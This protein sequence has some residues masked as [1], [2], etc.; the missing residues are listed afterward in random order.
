MSI[1]SNTNN[2]IFEKAG[3]IHLDPKALRAEK[4]SDRRGSLSSHSSDGSLRSI[5]VSSSGTH[6]PKIA[7]IGIKVASF[8][9]RMATILSLGYWN[10][11]TKVSFDG[12]HTFKWLQS[13]SLSRYFF[14]V[15]KTTHLVNKEDRKYIEALQKHCTKSK[16]PYDLD[17][18]VLR[19]FIKAARN[20]NA[21]IDNNNNTPTCIGNFLKVFVIKVNATNRTNGYLPDFLKPIKDLEANIFYQM[22]DQA[23]SVGD[24]NSQTRT[25]NLYCCAE[26]VADAWSQFFIPFNKVQE[27]TPRSKKVVAINLSTSSISDSDTSS[28]PSSPELQLAS[29]SSRIKAVWEVSK[30]LIDGIRNFDRH[31][32]FNNLMLHAT[33]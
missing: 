14:E 17:E 6:S 33:S 31:A 2:P 27:T 30:G 32:L 12:G 28:T 10:K 13:N 9:E 24:L 23:Q 5:S 19:G 4:V 15:F 3:H 22:S 21:T 18:S 8:W 1:S 16:G 26:T 29:P 7:N 11:A 25:K 20:N